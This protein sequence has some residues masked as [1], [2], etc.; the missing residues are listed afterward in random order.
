MVTFKTVSDSVGLY[1]LFTYCLFVVMCDVGWWALLC[2]PDVCDL[3][4]WIQ[5]FL[6][7]T[8]LD[9]IIVSRSSH[10]L[11][12]KFKNSDILRQVAL[13]IQTVFIK[14][15]HFEHS[16]KIHIYKT[17]V[18][19]TQNQTPYTKKPS[20]SMYERVLEIFS[21]PHRQLLEIHLIWV[22]ISYMRERGNE[23]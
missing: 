5:Y 1:T 21:L 15:S 17:A 14:T 11:L 23:H 2:R 8:Y 18:L 12:R 16:Q 7:E 6:F 10:N 13:G 3:Q 20:K 4:S 9:I 19:L 22:F